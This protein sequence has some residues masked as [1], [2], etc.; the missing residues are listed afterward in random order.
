MEEETQRQGGFDREV[1]VLRWRA[2][3]ARSLRFPGCDGRPGQPDCDV[4][5][6]DQG[7]LVGRPVSDAVFRFVFW[8]DSRLHPSSLVRVPLNLT[9]DLCN[10]AP[11]RGHRI[12]V[13][14]RCDAKPLA[15]LVAPARPR[16]PDRHLRDHSGRD[17]S[18]HHAGCHRRHRRTTDRRPP[19]REIRRTD[20]HGVG[21]HHRQA[22]SV[23]SSLASGSGGGH[24]RL[25][26][27]NVP[28]S[29]MCDWRRFLNAKTAAE[30]VAP[31]GV[32]L[33]SIGAVFIG[34]QEGCLGRF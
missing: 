21:R 33:A 19:T 7:S 31:R 27:R 20:Q 5:S 9:P 12:E 23:P 34:A 10:N 14:F 13:E 18:R 29:R 17:R 3:R 24:L 28:V 4:A 25:F 11:D 26:F 2:P 22:P 32:I 30:G 1:R 15:R 6:T 16:R 8:M